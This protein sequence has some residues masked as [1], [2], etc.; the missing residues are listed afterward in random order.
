[1]THKPALRKRG[2]YINDEGSEV[3]LP[4]SDYTLNEA[5]HEAA[6]FAEEHVGDWGRARYTGKR[7]VPL[8]D[9]DDWW[10]CKECPAVP[11]W[12]FETYEGTYRG[13][14]ESTR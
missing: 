12:S 3:Y 5:R 6:N 8:H 13:R 9:H 2:P 7:D 10:G 11:S 1:V 14:W 4:V